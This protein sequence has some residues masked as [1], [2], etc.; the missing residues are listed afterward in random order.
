VCEDFGVQSIF[1]QLSK[2]V[3]ALEVVGSNCLR[4]ASAFFRN[5]A[6]LAAENLF[7]RKQLVL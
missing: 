2:L 7:L 3:L 1:R 4:F 6:V 5:R